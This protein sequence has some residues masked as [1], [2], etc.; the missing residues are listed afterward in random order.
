MLYRDVYLSLGSNIGDRMKNL[1][2][3]RERLSEGVNVIKESG[4]YE[5]EP[6]GYR[7]QPPFYNQVLMVETDMDPHDLLRFCL[8]IER[9]MGRVRLVRWGSRVIDIDILAFGDILV[10][11]SVLELPHRHLAERR[12]ELVPLSEVAG[13]FVIK[14]VTVK[15]LLSKCPDKG[16]VR[17]VK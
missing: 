8:N 4:V 12:F 13:D 7:E 5:S 9:E 3:A 16:W 11:D 6:W 1:R 2:K 10:S 17:R 15:E 14:G